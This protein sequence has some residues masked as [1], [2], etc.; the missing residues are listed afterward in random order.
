M[1][2]RA[3]LAILLSIGI[4]YPLPVRANLNCPMIVHEVYEK[5]SAPKR[6]KLVA[7]AKKVAEEG[8]HL[9]YVIS[10]FVAGAFKAD[11]QNIAEINN[12]FM[13][14]AKNLFRETG[15]DVKLET[16]KVSHNGESVSYFVLDL[17][18]HNTLRD[19]NGSMAKLGEFSKR[20]TVDRVT[21]DVLGSALKGAGGYFVGATDQLVLSQLSLF[22]II[23]FDAVD[24]VIRH[25]AKHA[26]FDHNREKGIYDEYGFRIFAPEG[27]GLSEAAPSV[28]YKSAEELYT[29]SS[30]LYWALKRGFSQYNAEQRQSRLVFY[31]SL[32]RQYAEMI[33]IFR[34]VTK[35]LEGT[36]KSLSEQ[37]EITAG[38]EWAI[39]Q[40]F[41]NSVLVK[42]KSGLQ[43]Q[44]F[45]GRA[46]DFDQAVSQRVSEG[47]PLDTKAPE[48][49]ALQRQLFTEIH[50]RFEKLSKRAANA[51][52]THPELMWQ[53]R[54]LEI[55]N[56]RY[57][58]N[59]SEE[60][61]LLL[62]HTFDGLRVIAHQLALQT[63]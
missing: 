62:Q 29:Y 13:I 42:T 1:L 63:R 14:H 61:R 5:L 2:L 17:N 6:R 57:N 49:V 26:N 37:N 31:R 59:P 51:D 60:N 39:P 55:A 16:A 30:N 41:E 9:N 58:D 22:R 32:I 48:L 3:L 45:S 33:E 10:M 4:S 15:Y 8:F 28:R 25:E 27:R 36:F 35:E 47:K 52:A 53:L 38:A 50:R 21:I 34:S 18:I 24:M 43:V 19:S 12:R 46:K 7:K 20:F 40:G 56:K 54:K 23:V 44:A 11:L